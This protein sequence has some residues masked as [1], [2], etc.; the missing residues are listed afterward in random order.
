MNVGIFITCYQTDNIISVNSYH[1][2][3][4]LASLNERFNPDDSITKHNLDYGIP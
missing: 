4:S 3:P 2:M 1:C